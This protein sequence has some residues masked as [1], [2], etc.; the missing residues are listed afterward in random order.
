LLREAVPRISSIQVLWNP[1]N[2]ATAPDWKATQ[3]AARTLGVKL[4]S[5]EVRGAEDFLAA[6]PKIVRR[7]PT[8]VVMIGDTLTAAYPGILAEFVLKNRIPAI[9][10]FREFAEMGGLMSYGPKRTDLNLRTAKT[11]DLVLPPSLLLWADQVIE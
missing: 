8:A 4:E 2:P 1:A 9:T 10:E 5:L 3:A 11:L 7:Q 6:F